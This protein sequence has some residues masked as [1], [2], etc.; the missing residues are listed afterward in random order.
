MQ[1]AVITTRSCDPEKN[2]NRFI[3]IIDTMSP[4]NNS[5]DCCNFIFFI[6]FIHTHTHENI[7]KNKIKSSLYNNTPV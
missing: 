5:D 1:V 6:N 3:W 4:Q 7:E 2:F